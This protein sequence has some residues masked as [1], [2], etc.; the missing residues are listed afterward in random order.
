MSMAFQTPPIWKP[1][2]VPRVYARQRPARSSYPPCV[3]LLPSD[4]FNQ[5]EQQVQLHQPAFEE[6]SINHE[7]RSSNTHSRNLA[8]NFLSLHHG[9][10]LWLLNSHDTPIVLMMIG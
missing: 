2:H 1:L 8:L 7:K 9:C 3:R 5:K 4:H 6:V 10:H